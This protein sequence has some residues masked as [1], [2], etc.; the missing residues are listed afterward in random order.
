MSSGNVACSKLSRAKNPSSGSSCIRSSTIG[1]T[2]LAVIE[3]A[4]IVTTI[5]E[6]L[7]SIAIDQRVLKIYQ[8]E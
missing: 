8:T 6:E 7:K 3:P 5:S 1:M 2:T 4:G